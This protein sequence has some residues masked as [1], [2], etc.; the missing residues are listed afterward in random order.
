MDLTKLP[1]ELIFS[2]KTS[3][4]DY[5]IDNDSSADGILYEGLNNMS[6][7]MPQGW[8]KEKLFLTMFNDANYLSTIILLDKRFSLHTHSWINYYNNQWEDDLIVSVIIYMVS[9]YISNTI[10]LPNHAL[11]GAKTLMD[12]YDRVTEPKGLD[13][14]FEY[15]IYNSIPNPQLTCDHFKTLDIGTRL[16]KYNT[17]KGSVNWA[18]ITNNFEI[19]DIIQV[20]KAL[21]KDVKGQREVLDDIYRSF[22]SIENKQ[23]Y[24]L[25]I[26]ESIG[27]LRSHLT[28]EG[29]LLSK[30]KL[31]VECE[32]EQEFNDEMF[33]QSMNEI[34]IN[35]FDDEKRKYEKQIAE[36][37][38]EINKLAAE[39]AA[40]KENLNEEPESAFNT[41]GNTC[42]TK[43]KMGLLIHT[44]ASIT[45]GPIP[46]KT[47]LVPII[48]AI[49]GWEATSVSS[50][51]RKA[52]FKQID[53]DAVAELFE[54]AMPKFAAEI[55]KQIP[56]QSK[57]KK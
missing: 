51:I 39:N 3:I 4:D 7:N 49:G 9:F 55:K 53:I 44:I 41:N 52:G 21:G 10:D 33:Q 45:D 43:A 26:S 36:L 42:F 18:P 56:R 34:A 50:E 6:F 46:V 54:D 19:N 5:D 24:N 14:E 23:Y 25:E 22:N 16:L 31:I 11:S 38:A 15:Y 32:K 13:V 28:K 40:I 1:Q 47:Q 30:T 35:N 57:T 8:D 29:V 27:I 17:F 20:T 12:D 48:S 37:K 2:H